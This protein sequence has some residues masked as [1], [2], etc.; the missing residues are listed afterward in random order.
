MA[1]AGQ[2]CCSQLC[3]SKQQLPALAVC[4]PAAGELFLGIPLSSGD[5]SPAVL[6]H[7]GKDEGD[8]LCPALWSRAPGWGLNPPALEQWQVLNSNRC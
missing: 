4:V 1:G 8:L 5:V 6:G 3:Q 7:L 2:S